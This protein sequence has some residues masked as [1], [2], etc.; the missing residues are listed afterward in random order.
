MVEG[1]LVF[2]DNFPTSTDHAQINANAAIAE[3]G[4]ALPD[5]RQ[6]DVGQDGGAKNDNPSPPPPPSA[7]AADFNPADATQKWVEEQQ[8]LRAA[9]DDEDVFEDEEEDD[10]VV[11]AKD[12]IKGYEPT[13][14]QRR[15]TESNR[16]PSI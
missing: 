8:N 10:D 7:A 4:A 3:S 11:V 2:F 1:F 14:H 5:N 13:I 12:V 6:N 15:T 16:H 9:A